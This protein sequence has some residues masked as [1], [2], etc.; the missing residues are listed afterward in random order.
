MLM[1]VFKTGVDE[2][3]MLCQMFTVL[4]LEYCPDTDV[5]VDVTKLP[6]LDGPSQ[7]ASAAAKG[8]QHKSGKVDVAAGK[9]KQKCKGLPSK[10]GKGKRKMAAKTSLKSPSKRQS[11]DV[12]SIDGMRLGDTAKRG[13]SGASSC[14]LRHFWSHVK[15]LVLTIGKVPN[16]QC[17]AN[18]DR[19]LQ[20]VFCQAFTLQ[21]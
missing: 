16:K 2:F 11:V 19:M 7:D 15:P 13:K 17:Q 9:T 14:K 4:V 18:F 10:A 21:R 3:L 20:H 1:Q 12:E 5:D 8:N 6:S